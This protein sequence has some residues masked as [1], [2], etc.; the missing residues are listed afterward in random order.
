M[1]HQRSPR[2]SPAPRIVRRIGRIL[3]VFTLAAG[4][5]LAGG[6]ARADIPDHTGHVFHNQLVC[7]PAPF[8]RSTH[9]IAY[10]MAYQ[11]AGVYLTLRNTKTGAVLD[12][13]VTRTPGAESVP[14][15]LEWNWTWI[16][17]GDEAVWGPDQAWVTYIWPDGSSTS[18][19][20]TDV[21]LYGNGSTPGNSICIL[22]LP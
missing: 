8:A 14:G 16:R 22:W 4:F 17:A 5:T 1:D 11:P 18:E 2:Y 21:A 3:A 6:A 9:L 15:Q 20:L 19:Q 7:D 13:D 12:S 10:P